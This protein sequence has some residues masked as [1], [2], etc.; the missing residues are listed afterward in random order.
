MSDG[1]PTNDRT[2]R[3]ITSL[4]TD[5]HAFGRLH[6]GL[7]PMTLADLIHTHYEGMQLPLSSEGGARQVHGRLDPGPLQSIE[8]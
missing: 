3:R 4:Y 8:R 2:V 5:L 6:Q 1:A 7:P